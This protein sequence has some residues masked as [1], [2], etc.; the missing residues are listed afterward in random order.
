MASEPVAA[1]EAVLV[2]PCGAGA[3]GATGVSV[4]ACGT[5]TFR[6][7]VWGRGVG[8]SIGCAG[9]AGPFTAVLPMAGLA[10]PTTL[11]EF[12]LT[13]TGRSMGSWMPFPESTPGDPSAWVSAVDPPP[14]DEP[15]PCEPPPCEPPPV[16][17]AGVLPPRGVPG[18][19]LWVRPPVLVPV[20]PGLVPGGAVGTAVAR[21]RVEQ[22][23]DIDRVAA[24]VD[25]HVHRELKRV[26]GTDSRRTDRGALR[27]GVGVRGARREGERS[28]CAPTVW[29]DHFGESASWLPAF[30]RCTRASA[31]TGINAT[32]VR[33]GSGR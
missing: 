5:G 10:M 8:F 4:S 24:D 19:S 16:G 26:A 29:P 18:S 31:R 33:A 11:T 6:T 30:R 25:R 22:P 17:A 2:S 28:T 32:N 12:P 3:G 27:T 15:P 20:T 13:F 9:L 21:G 23:D 14:L 7:G 1:S